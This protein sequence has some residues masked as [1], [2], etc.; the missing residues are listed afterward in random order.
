M[1]LVEPE[2]AYNELT[3][4][5]KGRGVEKRVKNK[6]DYIIGSQIKSKRYLA[7]SDLIIMSKI[8][9]RNGAIGVIPKNLNN[10]LIS[11]TFLLFEI[12]EEFS[13][14]SPYF[15]HIFPNDKMTIRKKSDTNLKSEKKLISNCDYG[16]CRHNNSQFSYEK[17][18]EEMEEEAAKYVGELYDGLKIVPPGQKKAQGAKKGQ[19][20]DFALVELQNYLLKLYESEEVS[21]REKQVFKKKI[22]QKFSKSLLAAELEKLEK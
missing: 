4:R 21:E 3:I 2:K 5:I 15:L 12:K 11:S 22:A 1:A 8:D 14:L 10:S 13:Y 6:K 19:F 9:A 20:V 16:A 7:R 18:V 17:K